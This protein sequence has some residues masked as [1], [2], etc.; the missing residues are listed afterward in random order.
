[1]PRKD[2][3]R[4]RLLR[5]RRAIK[6]IAL[7]MVG[8]FLAVCAYMLMEARM[9]HLEYAD[10][11]LGDLPRAF[12]GVKLL[13]VSD[14]HVDSLNQPERVYA[15][16]QTFQKLEPDLLLLGGDYSSF[17]LAN[18]AR[19]MLHLD[20]QSQLKKRET[21]LR[22]RFF[23]K[24]KDFKA[25]LG[26]YAVAG[27]HDNWT[28]GLAQS[29][30]LGDVELLRNQ[31]VTIQKDGA[32]LVLA[33]LDDWVTGARRVGQIAGQV[34]AEDCVIVMSHNP[35]ALPVLSDQPGMGSARWAD[36]MLSGHTHGGQV[37]PFGRTLLIPSSY[38]DRYRTGWISES[39][40]QLLVSN[41]VGTTGFPIRLGAP[42]QAH[43][44]TLHCA[45]QGN[46]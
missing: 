1:M 7:A 27:N 42:A 9:V 22:D 38:G 18:E 44:I 4:G 12:D 28:D 40:T 32:S 13:Y 3:A 20:K 31:V 39:G 17:G 36:L 46:E 11:Q 16:M 8:L 19:L 41:G 6:S 5:R 43:L 14:L 33:G 25:P 26:K 45:N 29:L 23:S 34:R 21:A 30:A 15:L 24:L 2:R 35:D 37:R 10:V